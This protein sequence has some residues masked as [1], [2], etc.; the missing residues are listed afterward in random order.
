MN[1]DQRVS[2]NNASDEDGIIYQNKCE[3]KRQFFGQFLHAISS[4]NYSGAEIRQ[5]RR[6]FKC[7]E[8]T[9]FEYP[10]QIKCGSIRIDAC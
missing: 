4:G 5:A 6:F 9:Q 1:A 10:K 3:F 7:F 2:C 8:C